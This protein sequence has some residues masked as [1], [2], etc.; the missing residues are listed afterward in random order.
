MKTARPLILLPSAT[1]HAQEPPSRRGSLARELARGLFWRAVVLALALALAQL[2]THSMRSLPARASGGAPL[3]AD[4]AGD[5]APDMSGGA[6]AW[7]SQG[8]RDDAACELAGEP[9]ECR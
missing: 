6:P 8:F 4:A 7:L 3:T 1:R 2:A 5:V 9:V